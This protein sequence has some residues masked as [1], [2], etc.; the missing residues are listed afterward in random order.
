MGF[1][2][3]L[4]NNLPDRLTAFFFLFLFLGGLGFLCGSPA[5]AKA[6]QVVDDSGAV[7]SFNAPPKRVVSLVPSLTEIIAQIGAADAL[8]GITHHDTHPASLAGKKVVGGFLAPSI[9][10]IAALK[11]DAIFYG[12]LHHRVRAYF[13][14]QSV[15][16][17]RFDSGTVA[18]SFETIRKIG[19]VFDQSRQAE[20]IVRRNQAQLDLIKRKIA[21]LPAGAKKR[22]M[23][24]MGRDSAMT[25]G[26][27]SFQ[28][29]LIALAGG[30]PPGFMA[31]GPLVGVDLKDWRAFNPQVIYGC[32]GDRRMVER[33]KKQPAWQA[34]E[35]LQTGR[36]FFFPCDLTCRAATHTGYFVSWLS[37]RIYADAFSDP[38]YQLLADDIITSE[39][40]SI[41]LENVSSVRIIKTRIRDFEH[42]TLVIDLKKPT[43]VLSTLGGPLKDVRTVGNH[44]LPPPSWYL[45]HKMS[46]NALSAHVCEVLKIPRDQTA[47]LYTGADMDNLAIASEAFRDMMVTAFVTAGVTGNAVCMSKETG[48]YY[49]P[50]TINMIL[51]VNMALSPRARTRA[52]ITATEAKS[53]ALFDL[54]VRSSYQPLKYGATGTGTDNI[55][56]V[57]SPGV[58][59]DNAGGHTKMGELIARA[60]YKA[61]VQAVQKQNSLVVPRNI[62]QRLKERKIDLYT[63]L[64]ALGCPG[65]TSRSKQVQ[66]LEGLLLNPRYAGF[67]ESAL[68][69]SDAHTR[70]LVG[71]LDLFDAQCRRIAETIAGRP[72]NWPAPCNGKSGDLP[73][74]LIKAFKALL[75]GLNR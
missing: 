2:R 6:I 32:D 70:G 59:I 75:A 28:N 40:V 58:F 35:A 56:V 60:V 23:R 52:I 27:D 41:Q 43:P 15:A 33:L 65:Q 71:N 11:P 3:F 74:P 42:K 51:H 8:V 39:P 16:M 50:G 48:A 26:A 47:L 36:V 68:A 7:I 25:P 30:I 17:L 24:I 10:A 13:T 67:L 69:L 20:A 22:V 5:T 12:N 61:V 62:F 45:G 21:R 44:Y 31:D 72:L 29:E 49:E 19:L 54:D 53:A 57:P 63:V 37:A 9:S 55:I 46:V 66:A 64:D 73:E 4:P 1:K 38:K 34:V 18:H 14:D